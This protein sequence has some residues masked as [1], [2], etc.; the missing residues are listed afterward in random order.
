M[1]YALFPQVAEE[2]FARRDRKERPAEES[3]ALVAVVADLLGVQEE[4]RGAW[5]QR[6]RRPS[7]RK[8]SS[9]KPVVARNPAHSR[10]QARPGLPPDG[11]T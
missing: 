3:A 4:A 1:S 6:S 2:F 9:P 11:A 10:R 8:W 5:P 7:W